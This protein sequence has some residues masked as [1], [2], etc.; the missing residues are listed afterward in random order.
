M[1]SEQSY[2]LCVKKKKN[3]V[4]LLAMLMTSNIPNFNIQK[5]FNLKKNSAHEKDSTHEKHSKLNLQKTLNA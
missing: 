4:A 5:A 2:Y 1:I 3:S